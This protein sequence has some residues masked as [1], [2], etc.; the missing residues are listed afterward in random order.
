MMLSA[1]RHEVGLRGPKC[2]HYR[3]RLDRRLIEL[4]FPFYSPGDHERRANFASRA[5]LK[6]RIDGRRVQKRGAER[7]VSHCRALTGREIDSQPAVD[8]RRAI[9]PLVFQCLDSV[10][11]RIKV[12]V[13]G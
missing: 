1:R 4:H 5:V 11:I 7:H 6:F 13:V 8:G 9:D 2:K 12:I 3:G 10:R